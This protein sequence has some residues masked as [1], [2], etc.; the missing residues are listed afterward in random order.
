MARGEQDARLYAPAVDNNREPILAVLRKVMPAPGAILEIAS[1]SGQHA[2]WFAPEFPEHRW[3]PS[4][5][6]PGNLAS[7]DAWALEAERESGAGNILPARVVDASQA[8]WPVSD[9]A[10]DLVL[11]FSANMIHIAPW[12]AG[13]GLL[14]GAGHLL[15][16]Q[17]LLFLYGPFLRNGQPATESDA[18]F[19]R[20]L[21]ARNPS[22]GLRDLDQVV[23]AAQEQGLE[24]AEQLDMPVGNLSLIFR[25]R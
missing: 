18:E 21:K 11:M 8:D 10:D 9:I 24:L 6:D 4:D 23:A 7:I 20:S 5:F 25:S 3:A 22:W 2:S 1:G 19:D 13:L 16:D 14:A 12:S 17:G 15:P